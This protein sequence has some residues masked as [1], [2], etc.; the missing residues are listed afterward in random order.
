VKDFDPDD[1][2]DLRNLV[3]A[4]PLEQ[5]KAKKECFLNPTFGDASRAIGGADADI[6]VDDLLLDIKVRKDVAITTED[7][8][9]VIGYYLLYKIGGV[10]SD[11]IYYIPDITRVGFYSARYRLLSTWPLEECFGADAIGKD[12]ARC[13]KAENESFL[14]SPGQAPG[15]SLWLIVAISQWHR[16]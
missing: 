7:F 14:N 11:G 12:Q 2:A 10:G 6:I 8:H 9:Q 13:A 4:I 5:F 16:L 15:Y 1:I 3:T